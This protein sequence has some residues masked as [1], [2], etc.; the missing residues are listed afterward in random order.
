MRTL[1][2]LILSCASV[3]GADTA[4]HV[5]TTVRTNESGSVDTRDVFTRDG[6]TNLVRTTKTK[7]GV[8]QIRT[9]R[10]YHDG[11]LI[12][13]YVAMGDASS[14]FSTEGGCPYSITLELWPSKEVRSIVF[15]TNGVALDWFAC[16]NGVFTPVDSSLLKKANAF[17]EDLRP[18]FAPAH[19]TNTTPDDYAREIKQFIKKHRDK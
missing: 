15:G 6:Q 4:I 11:K 17:G 9:H 19:V 13:D 18:L 7:A 5:I 8:V 10:F 16:T 1:A 14:G 3:L 2:V 12:C